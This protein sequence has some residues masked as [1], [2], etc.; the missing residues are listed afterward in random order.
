VDDDAAIRRLIALY[1]QLIDDKRFDEWGAL[2]DDDAIFEARGQRWSGRDDIVTSISA[3]MATP[4][5]KH[6]A[7]IPV[8]DVAGD[9]TARAW[10]DLTTF[11]GGEGGVTIATI[12][13]YHDSFRRGSD[14]RWRFTARVLVTAGSG[15]LPHDA[16]PSPAS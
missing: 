12:G 15:A 4:I 7:G 3:L 5:T 2:F 11:I 14:G 6:L 16:V 10:T 8:V 1:S 9:G 13:R